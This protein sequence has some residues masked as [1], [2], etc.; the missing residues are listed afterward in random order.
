MMKEWWA[1]FYAAG[2]RTKLGP[3]KTR[4]AAVRAALHHYMLPTKRSLYTGY[5]STAAQFDLIWYDRELYDIL[6][7]GA[8]VKKR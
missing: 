4:G 8:K 1:H 2:R 3:F 7:E 6:A 5:G